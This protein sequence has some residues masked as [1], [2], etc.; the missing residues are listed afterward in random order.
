MKS[1]IIATLL[2]IACVAAQETLEDR[3]QMVFGSANSTTSTMPLPASTANPRAG[4]D[5]IVQ[6][7]PIV[8]VSI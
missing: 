7:D 2:L 8:E 5:V 6:P 1:I 3:I 4:F